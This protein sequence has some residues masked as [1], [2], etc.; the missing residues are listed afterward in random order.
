MRPF[1]LPRSQFIWIVVLFS[2]VIGCA[3]RPTIEIDAAQAIFLAD[4]RMAH[5]KEYAPLAY[6]AA[7]DTFNAAMSAVEEQDD[8]FSLF[9]NYGIA[10]ARL[11]KAIELS[12]SAATLAIEEKE[13]LKHEQTNM[14][15]EIAGSLAAI[16]SALTRVPA[17]KSNRA[18]FCLIKY[19]LSKLHIKY[20]EAK[21]WHNREAYVMAEPE[22]QAISRGAESLMKEVLAIID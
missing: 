12:N 8:K 14:M 10:K 9:R 20:Y 17:K 7:I 18:A 11:I 19:D 1:L 3:E 13:R 2:F 15:V 5:T 4:L 21:D 16:D 6:S 22:L